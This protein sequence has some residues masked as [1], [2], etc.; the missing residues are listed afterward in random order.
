MVQSFLPYVRRW[1][2]LEEGEGVNRGNY[3]I[4]VYTRILCW[5]KPQ[6]NL[7]KLLVAAMP[8]QL[9]WDTGRPLRTTLCLVHICETPPTSCQL[10]SAPV[11]SC[12]V[13]K[14]CDQLGGDLTWAE[15]QEKLLVWACFSVNLFTSNTVEIVSSI[16]LINRYK[17]QSQQQ[18]CSTL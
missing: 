4:R 2:Q 9:Q 16:A 11:T 8:V 13:M 14:K 15:E 6:C 10:L 18:S 12:Q 5:E 1:K 17:I 3:H 7:C